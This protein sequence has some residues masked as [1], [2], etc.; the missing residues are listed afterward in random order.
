MPF[1]TNADGDQIWEDW[2]QRAV[3]STV[4]IIVGGISYAQQANGQY[5]GTNGRVVDTAEISRAF[6]AG[7]AP[8][9][10][11]YMGINTAANTATAAQLSS[12]QSVS[13]DSMAASQQ[14]GIIAAGKISTAAI[15]A[16]KV[17]SDAAMARLKIETGPNAGTYTENPN[18]T[19]YQISGP[20]AG[21]NVSAAQF[22]AAHSTPPPPA[23]VNQP[24]K[25]TPAQPQAGNSTAP[26][27]PKTTPPALNVY[28]AG[29]NVSVGNTTAAKILPPVPTAETL[30]GIFKYV[31][32]FEWLKPAKK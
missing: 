18:G 8:V 17:I 2:G 27:N 21:R 19:F 11:S 12:A 28:T 14:A 23:A 30:G 24:A 31:F 4:P 22:D 20:L 9:E 15:A 7:E 6:Q 3:V 29:G 13:I 25:V 16:A 32:E 5:I 26:Y 10:T 1:V